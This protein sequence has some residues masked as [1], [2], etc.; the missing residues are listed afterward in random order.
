MDCLEISVRLQS[1]TGEPRSAERKLVIHQ[2]GNRP[3]NRSRDGA[4]KNRNGGP[5]H[6]ECCVDHRNDQNSRI[7]GGDREASCCAAKG[8][9]ARTEG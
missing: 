1:I 4:S 5:A 3:S 9:T 6:R 7:L 2:R 8:G